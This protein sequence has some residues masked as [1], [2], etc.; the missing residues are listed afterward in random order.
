MKN[1]LTAAGIEPATFR[2]VAQHLN[3]CATGS[4]CTDR[5]F[6][7]GYSRTDVANVPASAKLLVARKCSE[8]SNPQFLDFSPKASAV[9]SPSNWLVTV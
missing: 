1:L 5:N 3:H 9:H 2:F 8:L 4:W 7:F 6:Q